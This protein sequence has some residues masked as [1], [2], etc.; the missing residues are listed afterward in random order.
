L[1]TAHAGQPQVAAR[2][3]RIDEA[4]ADLRRRNVRRSALLLSAVALLFY[5][6]FIVL[7]VVR[8]G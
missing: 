1:S 7:S 5:V 3:E 4:Q 6:G 8:A 2:N